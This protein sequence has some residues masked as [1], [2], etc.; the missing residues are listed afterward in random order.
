MTKKHVQCLKCHGPKIYLI[1]KSHMFLLKK[2]GKIGLA[3]FI[4]N[5]SDTKVS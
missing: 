1:Y 2:Q 4:L 5:L 3:H